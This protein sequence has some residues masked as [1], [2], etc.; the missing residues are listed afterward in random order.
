MRF[1]KNLILMPFGGGDIFTHRPKILPAL[2]L[3][4]G[5]TGAF[6]VRARAAVRVRGSRAQR[7]GRW[8]AV[9]TSTAGNTPSYWPAFALRGRPLSAALS[10]PA[11]AARVRWRRSNDCG[12]WSALMHKRP[13]ARVRMGA[14]SV[15]AGRSQRGVQSDIRRDGD[16]RPQDQQ[17]RGVQVRQGRG[18]QPRRTGRRC[19]W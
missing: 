16:G 5:S 11:S 19:R 9:P 17:R 14:W 3:G 7:R 15:D 6:R 12:W 1:L 4:A 18:P 2:E 8:T 13:Q 10:S